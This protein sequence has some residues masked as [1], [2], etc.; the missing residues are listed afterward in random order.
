ME[1]YLVGVHEN[2]KDLQD[3]FHREQ[4]CP[5]W[6][7]NYHPIH[8]PLSPIICSKCSALFTDFLSPIE[9][10]MRNWTQAQLETAFNLPADSHENRARRYFAAMFL[11]SKIMIEVGTR[12]FNHL[13][14]QMVQIAK[15]HGYMG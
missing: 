11:M 12:D 14:T 15:K 13:N 6:E 8:K 4:Q 10:E 3:H 7:L 5:L 9:A 1:T 2:L